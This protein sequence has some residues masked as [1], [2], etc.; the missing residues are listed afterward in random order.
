MLAGRK[1]LSNIDQ[2]L[3]TVRREA[4][5]LDQQLS[6]LVGQHT[7]NQR[8]RLSLLEKLA[9]V[10]LN[11]IESGELKVDFDGVD[12][13]VVKILERRESAILKLNA[14]IDKLDRSID[15][16][17]SSRGALLE[18][19]NK[20]AEKLAKLEAKVQADLKVDE[21][22]IAQYQQ[23]Q[24]AESISEEAELKVET[25]NQ[26]MAEKAKPY[27]EDKL[28]MYLWE[29]GYGTTEYKA[30]LVARFMDDWVAKLIKYEAARV[31]FWNLN[32]IPKRLT[33]HAD[34]V[35]EIA[36]EAMLTLQQLE[37]DALIAEGLP[38]CEQ[39][40][41]ELR[42]QLDQHDDSLEQTEA[43]LNT[44]L[45]QRALY[46]SGNDDFMQQCVD[47]ISSALQH[48]QLDSIHR[49]VRQTHSP[50]D[51]EYVF[52]LQE[53]EDSLQTLNGEMS[54]IKRMHT[55]QISKL[56]ELESVR[57]QFKNSRYDDLRSGFTNEALIAGAL[58]Q[59]VQGLVS[60]ADVW[61]TIKR[62]QRYRDF[63]SAPDFGSGGL[64]DIADVLG[65][66]GGRLGDVLRPRTPRR[67]RKRKGSSWH[68]PTPR[69]GGGA[70]QFPRSTGRSGGGFK[71]G[72]GF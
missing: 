56:R 26:D 55:N 19:C 23:A 30:G 41:T 50:V 57:Q 65:T 6:Q 24:E 13:N 21:S 10:R 31:N 61:G 5:R 17:E 68:I 37:Q 44:A 39:E 20:V 27:Q 25:A 36:D 47:Q 8:H 11:E 33:E 64:G 45:E 42:S 12:S 32:E 1:A 67:R 59:F 58:A 43:E 46:N 70:F 15:E 2:T 4:V 60:G 53:L 14:L 66:G 38:E 40:L 54:G 9:K 51:D 48:K 18:N 3:Q 52:E 49:Y 69:R 63:G 22:Y 7:L 28:F 29:R 16:N 62:N 71:T 72:G 34:H 35:A